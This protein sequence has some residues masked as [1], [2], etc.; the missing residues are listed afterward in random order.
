M[1]KESK[2]PNQVVAPAG[3]FL[4]TYIGVVVYFID[5]ADGFWQVVFAFIQ[6]LVWPALLINRIFEVLRI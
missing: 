4:L 3:F 6:G 2:K 5:K 1:T